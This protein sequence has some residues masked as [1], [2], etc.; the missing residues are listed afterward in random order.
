VGGVWGYARM[1]AVL[2][3]PTDPEREHYGALA[4]RDFDP[5]GFDPARVNALFCQ[6]A[7]DR[8]LTRDAR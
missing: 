3:D 7:D 1:L 6:L 5:E 4:G 8:P 2:A